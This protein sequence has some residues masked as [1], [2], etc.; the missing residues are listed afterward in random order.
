MPDTAP[1]TRRELDL[2]AAVAPAHTPGPWR[3][4]ARSAPFNEYVFRVINIEAA[5]PYRGGVCRLQSSEHIG[6]IGAAETD[7]NARLIAAAPDLLAALRKIAAMDAVPHVSG[8][9]G[10]AEFCEGYDMAA[11]AAADCARAAIARAEGR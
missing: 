8:G 4:D 6:G 9:Q 3:I 11:G 2:S 5:G 10:D 1:T 7:A